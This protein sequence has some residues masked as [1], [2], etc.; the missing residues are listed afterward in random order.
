MK[1]PDPKSKETKKAYLERCSNDEG[2]INEYPD[3]KHRYSLCNVNWSK[4]LNK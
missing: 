3:K 2:M 1:I 4:A